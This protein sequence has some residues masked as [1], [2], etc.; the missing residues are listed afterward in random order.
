MTYLEWEN[1]KLIERNLISLMSNQDQKLQR[2]SQALE[3]H[4]AEGVSILAA[5]PSRLIRWA[6]VLMMALLVTGIA[7]SFIGRADVIVSAPGTLSPDSEVRRFYAPIQG[8]LVDLFIA[9]GLPV[10]KGDVLARLNARGAVEAATNVLDAE[11]K[12]SEAEREQQNFAEKKALMERQSVAL[13]RRI[14]IARGQH[15]KRIAE[16]TN[17]LAEAQRAKL[18]ETRGTLE[19]ARRVR[20]IASQEFAKFKRLYD[21]AGGGGVS[22][23]QVEEKRSVLMAANADL[24]IAEAKLGELDFQLSEE[25]AQAKAGIEGS[26]QQM[27]ELEIQLQALKDKMKYDENKVAT[28]LRSA[29]LNADA[30]SRVKFQN[31]DEDNFLRIVA[32][33]SGIITEVAFTQAG[34][35]VQ[36]NTPLGGIAPEDSRVVVKVEIQESDRAFLK[37]GQP[38]KMKFNA[39]P[40]QRYG[41]INGTLDYISPTTQASAKSKS[42]IYKGRVALAR[43]HFVIGEAKYPLR[44]GMEAITEIVVRKRRLID[45]ALDPFRQLAG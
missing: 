19:K 6:I 13:Q 32:P 42:P 30:A 37:E 8:E 26:D 18:E 28:G 35:K 10:S 29:Q 25:F 17:K 41:F 3:D 44:Y 2:L 22:K 20:Q 36:A 12:L 33:V 14:D 4:S 24:K 16:G 5:E 7:W 39:F 23:Q 40:Y 38:V 45:F 31:I 9:E 11:L 43:D 15:E 21:A 27:T 1:F 34:D